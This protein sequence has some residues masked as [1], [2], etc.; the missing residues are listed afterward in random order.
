MDKATHKKIRSR[1]KVFVV[2]KFSQRPTI[3]TLESSVTTP[4]IAK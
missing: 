2:T 3:A 4:L 1:H